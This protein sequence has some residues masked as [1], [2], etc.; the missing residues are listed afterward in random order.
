MTSLTRRKSLRMDM[1]VILLSSKLLKSTSYAW[2]WRLKDTPRD[3]TPWHWYETQEQLHNAST[4]VVDWHLWDSFDSCE[5][6]NGTSTWPRLCRSQVLKTVAS[7]YTPLIIARFVDT[8]KWRK[9]IK[10]DELVPTWDYPEKADI[11][12]YYKQFYHKVDNVRVMSLK[13]VNLGGCCSEPP[14][15]GTA[16]L[17][18]PL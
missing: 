11:E 6:E 1:L 5:L 3:S 13:A 7:L 2:C 10:L 14:L 16:T 15:F 8:E 12:K 9:D 18:V 17:T 4:C